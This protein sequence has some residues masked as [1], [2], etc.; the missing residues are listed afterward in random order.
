MSEK[1]DKPSEN[2]LHIHGFGSASVQYLCNK[3][4]DWDESYSDPF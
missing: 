4:K 3:G 1:G 2:L